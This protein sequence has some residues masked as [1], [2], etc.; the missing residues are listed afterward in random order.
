VS[1][2]VDAARAVGPVVRAHAEESEG[3]RRLSPAVVLVLVAGDLMRMCV[4][5]AYGG[6][7]AS[8]MELVDAVAA[9]A[10]ADGAA[11]WCAMIASTTSSMSCFLEPA[12]AKELFG[13]P[14]V[15]AGGAFAPG[16][17]G[18]AVDGGYRIEG[19]WRW[20]SGTQHCD[21]IT[22]GVNC[23]DGSFRLAFVPAADVEII[24][25]WYSV[26][27]RGTGS[28]DFAVHGAVVPV[29]RT[30]QPFAARP[31]LDA[32][33]ARFPNF[34]LLA[35]GVAAAMLGIAR[36]AIDELVA[37][38]E[39]KVP[40]FSSKTLSEST[41]AQVEL[42]RAEAALGAARAFL[43]DELHVAWERAMAGERVP[44]LQRARV[45][46]AAVHAGRE[47]VRAVDLAYEA[48]GG[49]SVFTAHPLQRC[50]RDV[51]TASQHLMVSP[52]VLETVG[53]VLMHVDA[54]TSAL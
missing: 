15:I 4:P 34:N 37:L 3:A 25:T 7:E 17:T 20:G 31:Q 21:W 51:H 32:P 23:D 43:L 36:R 52:R 35:S 29:A 53:R 50:F 49:S 16:G 5:A 12:T 47:S 19:R 33:L 26:G 1:G 6:P 2:L 44:E 39:G 8:P 46:L 27:L 22:G 38:A 30:V 40:V 18:A 42:A 24:D 13:E 45:R 48:G 11:G 9:V 14:A 41:L 28:N 54:D 10:E